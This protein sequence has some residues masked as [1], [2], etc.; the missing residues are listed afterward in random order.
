MR[1]I[2]EQPEDVKFLKQFNDDVDSLAGC[3]IEMLETTPQMVLSPVMRKLIVDKAKEVKA[4]HGPLKLHL[5]VD[6]PSK[7]LTRW[8]P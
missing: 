1:H 4:Q 5:C 3:V 2:D 8:S 6:N 7:P